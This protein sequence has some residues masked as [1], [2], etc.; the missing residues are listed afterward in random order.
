MN[1]KRL[2]EI[3]E[4]TIYMYDQVQ[5]INEI[6]KLGNTE[7]ISRSD[8]MKLINY[9]AKYRVFFTIE[10]VKRT[11]GQRR[12]MNG[13]TGVR[14]YV[15]GRGL[16]YD[17]ISKGLFTVYDMKAPGSG[18]DKYRQVPVDNI[19]KLYIQKRLFKVVDDAEYDRI[20]KPFATK[21]NKDSAEEPTKGVFD[22]GKKSTTDK[23]TSSVTSKEKP[24]FTTTSTDPTKSF[25]YRGKGATSNNEPDS[26]GTTNRDGFDDEDEEDIIK[27]T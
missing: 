23:T 17:N 6:V 21:A 4:H 27:P 2:N 19:T 10:F 15:N 26:T 9:T 14:R 3:V 13:L 24:K 20:N 18:K 22:R 5:Q 7:I 8:C 1:I 12:V 25:G 16:P 11:N